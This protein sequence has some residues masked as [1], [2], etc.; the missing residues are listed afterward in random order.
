V[1]RKPSS[2]FGV[3]VIILF[4]LSSPSF[5]DY[6]K[7]LESDFL[8]SGKKYEDRDIEDFSIDKQLN[9]IVQSSPM[10]PFSLLGNNLY[11]SL[12]DLSWQIPSFDQKPVTL[13]C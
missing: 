5:I 3:L 12:I 8:S 1:K 2:I 6:Q 13:R 4:F 7:L 10:P 9:F 11:N